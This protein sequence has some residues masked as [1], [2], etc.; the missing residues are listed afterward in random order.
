MLSQVAIPVPNNAPFLTPDVHISYGQS[1]RTNFYDGMTLEGFNPQTQ[2]LLALALKNA[3]F[4]SGVLPNGAGINLPATIN[5][6][7]GYTASMPASDGLGSAPYP[8]PASPADTSNALTVGRCS[9]L[10]YQLLKVAAGVKI[11]TPVLEFCSAYPSSTWTSGPGGGLADTQVTFTGSISSTTLTVSGISGTLVAGMV[12]SGTGVTAGTT[13]SA[14][15]TNGTT[16]T[17][18]NGT[19]A[20]SN[21]MT[22]SS[23][24]MTARGQSWTNLLSI[25]SSVQSVLPSNINRLNAAHFKS[26]GWTQ[27]GSF[28]TSSP[29]PTI[30]EWGQM[31]AAFDALNLPGAGT[32]GLLFYIGIR[33][34]NSDQTSQTQAVDGAWQFVRANANG[35]TI[36]TTPWYA[37]TYR[38]NDNIHTGSYGTQRHGE[39]EGLAKYITEYE[40]TQFKPLWRSL[41]GN[42]TVSGQTV[43]VPF[44][45]PVGTAFAG[46]NMEFYWDATDGLKAWP[47]QG[48]QIYRSGVPLTV[49]PTISGMNVVLTVTETLSQGDVLEVSYA[50]YGP[51]GPSP[52]T[53]PGVGGNLMMRGPTSPLYP[54]RTINA[55]A[56]PMRENVTV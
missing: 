31:T 37:W 48:F 26:V 8:S 1:W 35:R 46:K 19:Y 32:N 23:E 20:L 3:N 7:T 27:G 39:F 55:W 28:D 9:I 21:S 30:T 17:G 51:G 45:R 49:T 33:A 54:D 6:V 24:A 2:T 42:I 11:L 5:G 10:A 18:G 56:W 29:T 36:G 47:Q 44:D 16:G 38:G 15:G 43:T 12:V 25:L 53:V 34:A 14:F 4:P 13:I 52:G 22:V 40:G 50:Y 41:T